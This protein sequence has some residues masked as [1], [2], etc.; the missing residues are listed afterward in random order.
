MNRIRVALFNDRV[1]AEPLWKHLLQA[2]VPAEIHNEPWQAR[3]WFV[4]KHSAGVRIEV[5]AQLSEIT[6]KLLLAWNA[7]S[8]L[9]TGICCPECGSMRV[10][11]PQF[12]EESIL[13]NLAIGLLAGLGL[14][15]K[16]YYCEHCHHMWP[17]LDARL[18]VNAA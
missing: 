17:K 2:G 16:D 12:A 14:V 18:R 7:Q 11:F 6:E 5:P 15:E 3:L 9:S 13:T 10:D 1:A 4:S 8:F